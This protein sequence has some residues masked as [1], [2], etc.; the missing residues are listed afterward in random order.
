M[1]TSSDIRT[2]EELNEEFKEILKIHAD[3]ISITM[4]QKNFHKWAVPKI[5]ELEK[6]IKKFED[7]TKNIVNK[8]S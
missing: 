8:S 2:A 3:L 4:D 6:R 7:F 1:P 5:L